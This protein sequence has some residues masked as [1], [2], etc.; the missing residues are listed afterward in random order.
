MLYTGRMQII[1]MG[2][3]STHTYGPAHKPQADI[4]TEICTLQQRCNTNALV[5]YKNGKT[6]PDTGLKG[7]MWTDARQRHGTWRQDDTLT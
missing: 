3:Y 7:H 6:A 1:A 4:T 2:H 5:Y